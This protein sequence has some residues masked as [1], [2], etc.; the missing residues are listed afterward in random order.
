MP[1]PHGPFHVCLVKDE[2]L[3]GIGKVSFFRHFH[4]KGFLGSLFVFFFC[5]FFS[6]SNIKSLYKFIY[7]GRRTDL[8]KELMNETT[9][10]TLDIKCK[11]TV[12]KLIFRIISFGGSSNFS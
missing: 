4:I 8:R 12:S 10:H 6:S 9:D 1:I 5:F 3:D 7:E 2:I 11:I